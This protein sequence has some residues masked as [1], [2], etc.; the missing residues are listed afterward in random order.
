MIKISDLNGRVVKIENYNCNTGFNQ[1]SV[2]V[3]KLAPGTYMLSVTNDA[4]HN[5]FK[6]VIQ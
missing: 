4:F 5:Q 2:D 3:S 1:K 6:I